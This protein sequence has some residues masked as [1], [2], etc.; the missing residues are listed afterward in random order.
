MKKYLITIV[1]L[2]TLT[3]SAGAAS[4]NHRHHATNKVESVADSAQTDELEAYSD[5][6]GAASDTVN[7]SVTVSTPSVHTVSISADDWQDFVGLSHLSA[8]GMLTAVIVVFCI[9]VLSPIVILGLLFF[10]VYKNRKQRLQYAQQAMMNGQTV[11]DNIADT[12]TKAP[13]V[14]LRTKGIRQICLGVGLMILLYSIMGNLGLGI[15]ALVFCIGL[16]NL[17][18]S[19]QEHKNDELSQNNF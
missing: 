9:F 18:I 4:Q 16:G 1:M 11:A 5:T 15:G 2:L 8:Y 17:L 10:F 19:R 14:D 12:Q 13:I 7:Y 3:I 6:T